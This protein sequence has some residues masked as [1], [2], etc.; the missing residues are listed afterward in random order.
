MVLVL[1]SA[2]PV[3]AAAPWFATSGTSFVDAHGN[4]VVLRGVDVYPGVS[5]PVVAIGANFARVF[6]PWASVEPTAPVDGVHTWSQSVLSEVDASVSDLLQQGVA[7]EIDFHQC[8]WSPYFQS[9]NGSGCAN[10]VPAWYYADGR[11]PQTG[12]GEADAKA[13]FWTTEASQSEA[14]YQA[15]AQMMVARYSASPNVIGYGVFNEPQP[16]S[17]GATTAATNTMLGWQVT[18]ARAIRAIDP[19]RTIFFMA[20]SGGEGVTTADFSQ[21]AGLGSVALD[22]HDY[23]NGT[24][25]YGFDQTGDNWYPSWSQTHNQT[26]TDYQGTEAAQEQVLQVVLAKTQAAGIPLL[27]GEWGVQ[28]TDT[29]A[30]AYQA[31]MLDLFA[32]Y[33]LSWARWDIGTS[34]LFALRNPDGTFNPPGLQLQQT[35]QAP[36][37]PQTPPTAVVTPHITGAPI[38]GQSLTASPGAWTQTPET[39][40]YQWQRCTPTCQPIPGANA[41]TYLLTSDDTDAQLT[42]TIT[43]TNPA[44]ASLATSEPTT[45]VLGPPIDIAPPVITGNATVGSTLSTSTGSWKGAPTNYQY[46]WSRCTNQCVVIPTATSPTYTTTSADHASTLTATVTAANT[47]GQATATSAPTATIISAPTN[48][49]PPTITGQATIGATLTATPGTWTDNPTAYTYQW[50]RCT[51]KRCT[52]ILNAKT[53]TYQIS[54]SDRGYRL[55]I[56]VTA[57]N[58]AGSTSALSTKTTT[59]A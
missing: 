20:R 52:A 43:A 54:K 37:P 13:A 16:G 9:A 19:Q 30:A 7:V 46:Q 1:V 42:V 8:G 32:T 44:G 51:Q 31:Q 5:A 25:G 12:Q 17:L 49:N 29:G 35:L 33:G 38:V 47:Y 53:T 55:L 39:F 6:V 3:Q 57:T 27:V 50:K 21:L 48:T 14:A 18:V 24:P 26:S 4:P 59:V 58:Q 56:V 36:P 40:T 11:F 2:G 10:G 15:F 45:T 28:K 22:F 23:F 34:D 41:P